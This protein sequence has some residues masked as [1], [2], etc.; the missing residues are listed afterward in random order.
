MDILKI[1]NYAQAAELAKNLA[2]NSLKLIKVYRQDNLW[3]VIIDETTPTIEINH[4]PQLKANRKI[5][6]FETGRQA[7]AS[8]KEEMKNLKF[9]VTKG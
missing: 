9:N 5:S 7:T 3:C 4:K 1:D 6:K 2:T 8:V